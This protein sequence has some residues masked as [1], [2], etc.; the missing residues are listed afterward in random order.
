M[1]KAIKYPNLNFKKVQIQ[2]FVTQEQ[3]KAFEPDSNQ[4]QGRN[5]Q[6]QPELVQIC[7][8]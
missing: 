2:I 8:I 6:A 7:L 3:L 4:N 1:K 5:G